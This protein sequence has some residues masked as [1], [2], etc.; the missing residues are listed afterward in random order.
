ML[1]TYTNKHTLRA[2]EANTPLSWDRVGEGIGVSIGTNIETEACIC[3]YH[4]FIPT[5][6]KRN[7]CRCMLV[8]IGTY[9]NTCLYVHDVFGMYCG[10]YYVMY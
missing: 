3:T 7:T 6:Y 4:Y 9:C 5:K 10:M 2:A 1:S 8:C